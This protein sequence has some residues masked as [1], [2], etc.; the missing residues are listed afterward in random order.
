MMCSV[1]GSYAYD[2]MK[3]MNSCIL[4]EISF[5]KCF[6]QIWKS[7]VNEK[8]AMI[9]RMRVVLGETLTAK[10][11]FEKMVLGGSSDKIKDAMTK[12]DRKENYLKTAIEMAES[13]VKLFQQ[14]RLKETRDYMKSYVEKQITISRETEYLITGSILRINLISFNCPEKKHTISRINPS[15]P[16]PSLPSLERSISKPKSFSGPNSI[17]SKTSNGH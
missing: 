10:N 6:I 11:Y 1:M 13:E 8:I 7:Y 4:N 12:H 15:L 16:N 5:F 17:Q 9:E 14:H 2:K 3:Q